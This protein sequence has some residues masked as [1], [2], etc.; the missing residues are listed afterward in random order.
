MPLLH[1]FDYY[2]VVVS[3]G[4]AKYESTN[5]VLLFQDSFCYSGHLIIPHE[6]ENLLVRFCRKGC[7]NFDRDCIDKS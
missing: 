4:I 3:F 1:Y 6:F 7:W 5:F 2:N